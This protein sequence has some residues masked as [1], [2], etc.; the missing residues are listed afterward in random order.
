MF[1]TAA[2]YLSGPC[3]SSAASGFGMAQV[4]GCLVTRPRLPLWILPHTLPAPATEDRW[5]PDSTISQLHTFLPAVPS[6][7]DSLP[8][9]STYPG[10]AQT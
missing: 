8:L 4:G 1:S 10:Q 5:L 7:Q 3:T 2:V 9:P 6:P